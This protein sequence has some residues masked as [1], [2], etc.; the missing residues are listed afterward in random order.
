MPH[1]ASYVGMYSL[2]S[3]R[4][5]WLEALV[6]MNSMNLGEVCYVPCSGSPIDWG[7]LFAAVE[8]AEAAR[9]TIEFIATITHEKTGTFWAPRGPRYVI[10]H[11]RIHVSEIKHWGMNRDIGEAERVLGKNLPTP[12]QLPWW[13]TLWKGL[14]NTA[15]LSCV[16]IWM[17]FDRPPWIPPIQNHPRYRP[18]LACFGLQQPCKG[19]ITYDWVSPPKVIVIPE[20]LDHQIR[21]LCITAV[22]ERWAL[23]MTCH[24]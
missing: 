12:L 7:T 22:F 23:W 11:T 14:K 16:K 24:G 8:P 17:I 9:S 1:P 5:I 21:P 20:L 6:S 10:F 15:F 13:F 4:L 3:W 19:C 2:A 18:S